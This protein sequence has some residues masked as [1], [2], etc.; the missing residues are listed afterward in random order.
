LINA[1]SGP[2][3]IAGDLVHSYTQYK[4]EIRSSMY[5]DETI[6]KYFENLRLIKGM[7]KKYPQ[8]KL[9]FSHIHPEEFEKNRFEKK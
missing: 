5:N 6:D 7:S 9:L 1:Q 3:I 4:Y 8:I 2:V